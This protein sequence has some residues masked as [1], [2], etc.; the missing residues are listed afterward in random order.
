MLNLWRYVSYD[1][2]GCYSYQ[3]LACHEMWSA[4]TWPGYLDHE[5][6]EYVAVWKFCPYCGTKWERCQGDGFHPVYGPRRQRIMD[7]VERRREEE[8]NAYWKLTTQEKQALGRKRKPYRFVL[9]RRY[10]F[11][12]LK[13]SCEPGWQV[14]TQSEHT[15]G[16]IKACERFRRYREIGQSD[17]QDDIDEGYCKIDY[18]VRIERL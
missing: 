10:Q 1:E 18:R 14:L 16:A 17:H 8:N 3:C 4:R 15:D 2:D 9:E 7:A 13:D 12:R 6:N 11:L 5:T